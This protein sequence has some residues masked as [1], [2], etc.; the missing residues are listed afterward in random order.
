MHD[1]QEGDT[2]TDKV[3]KIYFLKE[4]RNRRVGTNNYKD[5]FFVQRI[6]CEP[7]KER[8]L[9]A[10]LV[11]AFSLPYV[12]AVKCLLCENTALEGKTLCEDCDI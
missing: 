8:W 3:G 10:S 12:E 11:N 4:R 1:F 2:V 6:D 9:D 7:F 5:Q